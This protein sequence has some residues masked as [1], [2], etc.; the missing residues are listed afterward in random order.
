MLRDES[1]HR[2]IVAMIRNEEVYVVKDVTLQ[3]GAASVA[4][5]A[6]LIVFKLLHTG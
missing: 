3:R 6:T 1:L 4:H 2:S 5:Y